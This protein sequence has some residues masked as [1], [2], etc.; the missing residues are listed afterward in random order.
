M[1]DRFEIP[2][3]FTYKQEPIPS[4]DVNTNFAYI[5]AVLNLM[6]VVSLGVTAP[7]SPIAG[8]AWWDTTYSPPLQRVFTDG[9][10]R[11]TDT[12]IGGTADV[13]TNPAEG[14]GYFDEDK[15]TFKIYDGSD[16]Q[17][18]GISGGTP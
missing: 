18:A 1:A 7:E 5:I 3:E 16:W 2:V 15:S 6:G 8:M 12:R 11:W 17:A 10:W 14:A 13:P 9:V 4:E